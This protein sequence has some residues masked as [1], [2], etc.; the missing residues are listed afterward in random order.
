MPHLDCVPVAVPAVHPSHGPFE[1][2]FEPKSQ[3]Q[4]NRPLKE[5]QAEKAPKEKE[6]P[7]R[8]RMAKG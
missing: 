6:Q 2:G 7:A 4:Q 8:K 1:K 5:V 3:Q